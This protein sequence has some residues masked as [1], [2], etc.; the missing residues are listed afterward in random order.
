GGESAGVRTGDKIV[1]VN[2]DDVS[3][4]PTSEV[5]DKA[6]GPAGTTV[7][8]TFDRQGTPVELTIARAQ[9]TTPLIDSGTQGGDVAYVRIKQLISTV[10]DDATSAIRKQST[11]RGVILDLRDDPG[12]ELSVAGDVGSMFVNT[13][14]LVFQS[15]RDGNRTPTDVNPRRYRGEQVPVVVLVNKNSAS[16]SEIIAAGV[17][18]SGAGTVMGTQTAGCVGSGQPHDLP[19]GGL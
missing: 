2:G 18:S 6:R 15:G 19:D 12:G 1:R 16:G 10:A 14:A 13:G 4:L 7:T 9:F 8:I 3:K 11:A 17:R 5:A